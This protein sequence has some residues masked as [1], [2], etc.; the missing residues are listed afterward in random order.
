MK[1]KKLTFCAPGTPT[2]PFRP[3]SEIKRCVMRCDPWGSQKCTKPGFGFS[4]VP[5]SCLAGRLPFALEIT[6][7]RRVSSFI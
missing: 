7:S 4:F 5:G 3:R 2:V 1:G 6:A